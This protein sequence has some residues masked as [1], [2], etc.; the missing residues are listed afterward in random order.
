ME[1][2]VQN[3]GPMSKNA[4][5]R[6]NTEDQLVKPETELKNN[7]ECNLYQSDGAGKR[8]IS[9]SMKTVRPNGYLALQSFTTAHLLV[10]ISTKTVKTLNGTILAPVTGQSLALSQ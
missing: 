4:K 6:V 2:T 7:I 3:Q 10:A 5:V 1:K 8:P 9:I